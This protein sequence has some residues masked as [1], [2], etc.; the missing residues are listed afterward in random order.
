MACLSYRTDEITDCN[1]ITDEMM[2]EPFRCT[3]LV[4]DYAPFG[5]ALESV[6]E[7]DIVLFIYKPVFESANAA[8]T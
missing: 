5:T 4:H 8:A 2:G 3:G 7:K 6:E 1:C